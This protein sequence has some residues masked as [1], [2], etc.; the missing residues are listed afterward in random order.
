M[1]KWT[2][3]IKKTKLSLKWPNTTK[4]VVH[5]NDEEPTT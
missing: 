2:E 4:K 5:L 3:P 1:A